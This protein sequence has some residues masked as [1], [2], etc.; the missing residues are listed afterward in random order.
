MDTTT[1]FGKNIIR[2]ILA[3]IWSAFAMWFEYYIITHPIQADSLRF[4]DTIL[5]FLMGTIV[6]GILNYFFGS[7]QS[8]ADKDDVLKEKAKTDPAQAKPATN[9]A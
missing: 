8:S 6:A 7:S 9:G 4:V 1:G 2:F 3:L 5:G